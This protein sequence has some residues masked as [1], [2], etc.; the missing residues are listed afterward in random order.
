MHSLQIFY[1]DK[2]CS[3][4]LNQKGS[5]L[6]FDFEA[7]KGKIRL[8][9]KNQN[10]TFQKSLVFE[11]YSIYA[12]KFEGYFCY[13]LPSSFAFGR[14]TLFTKEADLIS[15]SHFH[16]ENGMLYDLESKNGTYVN[17]QKCSQARLAMGDEIVAGQMRMY[18]FESVAVCS[19]ALDLEKANL[20]AIDESKESIGTHADFGFENEKVFLENAQIPPMP[21]PPRLFSTIG[22]SLMIV[23]SVCAMALISYLLNPDRLES[24]MTMMATSMSMA[25]A[26]LAYALI[27]QNLDKKQHKQNHEK[28]CLLYEQYLQ[29]ALEEKKQTQRLHQ[30]ALEE[31]IGLWQEM[32][33]CLYGVYKDSA[34]RLPIGVYTREWLELETGRTSYQEEQAAWNQKRKKVA[35]QMPS[36]TQDL[37]F[38]Q[39]GVRIWLKTIP[40]EE[41]IEA[42][43]QRFIFSAHPCKKSV[44][45]V[46]EKEDSFLSHHPYVRLVHPSKLLE[47]DLKNISFAICLQ[48]HGL[49]LLHASG[50]PLLYA[51]NGVHGLHWDSC[52]LDLLDY[53]SRKEKV[54]ALFASSESIGPFQKLYGC[55]DL[56][57][58]SIKEKRQASVNLKV[59]LGLDSNGQVVDIDLDEKSEGPHILVAGMTGSGKSEFLNALLL[60]LCFQNRPDLF[61]FMI[62]DFKGGALGASFYS[63]DHCA[64]FVSNL[65]SADMQRFIEA[66]E[67]EVMHRQK[68]LAQLLQ[69][70]PSATAHIDDWNKAHPENPLSHLLIVVD[71]FAQLKS[72]MPQT[73]SYMKELARIGRSL[74]FHLILATQKPAGIV[75]EQIWANSRSR[76]CLKVN[77]VQDSREILG[78]E[79][80]CQLA[81]SGDLILQV[82][83]KE[84]EVTARSFY[85]R[86]AWSSTKKKAVRID[87]FEYRRSPEKEAAESV[88][89][90]LSQKI[91]SQKGT[92]RIILPDFGG[93]DAKKMNDFILM[94]LPFEQSVKAYKLQPKKPLFILME[95]SEALQPLL[96]GLKS[97][98]KEENLYVLS[99]MPG[100][101]LPGIG[102][103]KDFWKAQQIQEKSVLVYIKARNDNGIWI[104]KLSANPNLSLIVLVGANDGYSSASADKMAL[105]GCKK[106]SIRSFFG[107]YGPLELDFGTDGC[108]ALGSQLIRV[109]M[110]KSSEPAWIAP[111]KTPANAL[112]IGIDQNGAPQFLENDETLIVAYSHTAMRQKAFDFV[113]R[114]KRIQPFLSF[115]ALEQNG[116]VRIVDLADE[117]F[118]QSNLLQQLAAKHTLLWIGPSFNDWALKLGMRSIFDPYE[119]GIL[120][121]QGTSLLLNHLNE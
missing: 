73:M 79:K 76:I 75:D 2:T 7:V 92:R 19:L 70:N 101:S 50:L 11:Q 69:E 85:T 49:R 108:M 9:T 93:I 59:G 74:G 121:R 53:P 91:L 48:Q 39:E 3:L 46:S 114:L 64:G 112:L 117:N 105:P 63:F 16:I 56:N 68:K 21:A 4:L 77:S 87:G 103:E 72:R 54:R 36:S 38:L 30:K 116:Q 23:V 106:E 42:L 57:E 28:A 96:S 67:A 119:A 14:N 115:S 100:V 107:Y 88:F 29:S 58:L 20:A 113:S 12:Q 82:G 98:L 47:S 60:Q 84:R 22:S 17:G 55:K 102:Y 34:F 40:S 5:A 13:K 83:Q 81:G 109:R 78:H 6:G 95:N 35:A 32:D 26:F 33:P 45:L 44:L 110:K 31:E 66:M 99:S 8:R 104:E 118:Q 25:F 90:L 71:E 111:L 27:N 18:W 120:L 15:A 24:V 1:D 10:K 80:G 43:L 97:S 61:Q 51:G 94:D 65:E 52:L 37:A 62:I 86:M 89:T 41:Q